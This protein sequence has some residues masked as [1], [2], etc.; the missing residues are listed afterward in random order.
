[1]SSQRLEAFLALLYTD[2]TARKRFLADPRGEAARAGL[3]ESQ[4]AS[5]EQIDRIGLELSAQSLT[6]K[7]KK[8]FKRIFQR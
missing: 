1:M 5:L 6:G 7:K 8:R 4:I 3:T 2:E